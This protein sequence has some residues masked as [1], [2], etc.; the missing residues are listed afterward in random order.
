VGKVPVAIAITPDGRTAYV[1]NEGSDD[2]T[3]IRTATG[4]PLAPVR[5]GGVGSNPEYIVI[6]PDG[7][8]AYVASIGCPCPPG[9]A[10]LPSVSAIST[11]TNTV[12]KTFAH[13]A[14]F[15]GIVMD[16]NG[17]T[18]YLLPSM[19]PIR[20][21]TNTALPPIRLPGGTAVIDPDAM[22]FSPDGRTGYIAELNPGTVSVI[23]T[24]TD[25]VTT[26]IKVGAG[27][28]SIALSPDGA[29]AYVV[30]DVS[31]TVSVI[32]TAASRVI[33]TIKVGRF[34]CC[35]ALTP[36][37][38]TAYLINRLSDT[39]SMIRT[40]TNTVTKTVQVKARGPCGIAITP[41]G[42]TAYVIDGYSDTVT[43]ISTAT[44]SAGKPIIVGPGPAA[45][46]ITPARHHRP[47]E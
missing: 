42:K 30:N 6:T 8:T 32:S 35:I 10:V 2:V 16:P 21:A 9:S 29:T 11:A 22:A 1:V 20:T 7:K 39:V 15:N 27:P 46:A 17:R 25:T 38:K 14:D 5:T 23:R 28:A 13:D 47:P 19:I 26:T 44:S 3:P 33:K 36:D 34:P 18:A 24:A 45:I 41:D 37:G 40:A 31:D 12:V 43:P 4:T